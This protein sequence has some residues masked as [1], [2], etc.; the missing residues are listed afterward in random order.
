M[1]AEGFVTCNL[2]L[3]SF[4]RRQFSSSEG[5]FN[6]RP[7]GKP[8][9]IT[10]PIPKEAVNE[11]CRKK[12]ASLMPPTVLGRNERAVGKVN[13]IDPDTACTTPVDLAGL[14]LEG[15]IVGSVDPFFEPVG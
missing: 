7:Q 9:G 12:S 13:N 10:W 15:S 8:V 5:P 3:G 4:P 6:C 1:L 11:R 2:V 14:H